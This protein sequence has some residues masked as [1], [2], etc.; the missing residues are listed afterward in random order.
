MMKPDDLEKVLAAAEALIS[1]ITSTLDVAGLLRRC[2]SEDSTE[3]RK[4]AVEFGTFAAQCII[5]GRIG[6]LLDTVNSLEAGS[7]HPEGTANLW[8][9]VWVSKKFAESAG[10]DQRQAAF[11]RKAPAFKQFFAASE[12]RRYIERRFWK[13][14]AVYAAQARCATYSKISRS[15]AG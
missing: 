4:A 1:E 6:K 3:R 9:K 15:V 7:K 12:V 13:G 10:I 14:S 8:P 2:L 11:Y 5:D